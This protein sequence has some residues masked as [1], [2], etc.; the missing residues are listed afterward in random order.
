[1]VKLLLGVAEISQIFCRRTW[2]WFK[3]LSKQIGLVK[4]SAGPLEV[5]LVKL[6][7]EVGRIGLISCGIG[8]DCSD[9]LQVVGKV[10]VGVIKL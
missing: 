2:N 7:T 6:S 8:Q 9:I 3:F 10:W 1:M 5:G 4:S